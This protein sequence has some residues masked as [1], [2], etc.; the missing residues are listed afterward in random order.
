[1]IVYFADRSMNIIGHA[2]D[3]IGNS[4]KIANDSSVQEIENGVETLSFDI[5]F[6]PATRAE[7]EKIAEVGNYILKYTGNKDQHKLY[8]IIDSELNVNDR[9]INIF[10]ED[11][12]L[13]LL[14]ETAG[15]FTPTKEMTATEYIEK[16]L[17][18]TG[19][20]IG[21]NESETTK[22]AIVF[23]QDETVTKRILQIASEFSLE[24]DYSVTIK[25]LSVTGK[26][27]N[28]YKRIGSDKAIEL[29][30][31][32][33]IDNIIVKKSIANLCTGIYPMGSSPDGSVG[34]ISGKTDTEKTKYT[35]VRF[36][37][38]MNGADGF[39][40][41]PSRHNFIGIAEDKT[42][43][44]E[45]ENYK[46]YKWYRL[47]YERVI[48]VVPSQNGLLYKKKE[49]SDNN[50]YMWIRFSENED[51]SNMTVNP[52]AQT[53]YIG[54]AE[55][56][57]SSTPSS[58]TTDYNWDTYSGSDTKN[59]YLTNSS[60]RLGDGR[61]CLVRFADDKTGTNMSSSAAGKAYVGFSCDFEDSYSASAIDYIWTAFDVDSDDPSRGANPLVNGGY[62]EFDW[63]MCGLMEYSGSTPKNTYTWVRFAEDE[64]GYGINGDGSN[65]KYIGFKYGQT[66]NIP[67]N[68]A[69]VYSWHPV[70]GDADTITLVGYSYDKDD[71]YVENGVVY[72][73][74]ATQKWSRY[75][76]PFETN[77]QGKDKG[78]IVRRISYNFG[79]PDVLLY[80]AIADLKKYGDPEV[81]YDVSVK[82]LP[83]NVYIGDRI[84]IVDD[85]GLL[86]V[87]ARILQIDRSECND[88]T[89]ITLGEFLIK[90]S[91]ISN[92]VQKL[93]NEFA[94]YAAKTPQKGENAITIKMTSSNGTSFKNTDISTTLIAHVY[95]GSKE[96]SKAEVAAL[97]V[98]KW[99]RDGVYFPNDGALSLVVTGFIAQTSEGDIVLPSTTEGTNAVTQDVNGYI[100]IPATGSLVGNSKNVYTVQLETAGV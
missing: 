95:S 3:A 37:D 53:R 85:A 69:S 70:A 68:S 46:D 6:T 78:A 60:Y 42:E 97:G 56:M 35:W 11:G 22:K 65:A 77:R 30:T 47:N 1:M 61:Y 20:K 76:A 43:F 15:P 66:T 89:K 18:D 100:V 59:L 52:N 16:Y 2:S 33:E 92:E 28:I 96:L 21:K 41:S 91:G 83:E 93:A 4:Y 87:S 25:G 26:F 90:D 14:N 81:N 13:D 64:T 39:E 75:Q 40:D 73:R 9:T 29:R 34:Y 17:Y 72:S 79:D 8:T 98:L 86:Y 23:D 5:Y 82:Y 58:N 99:Y 27:I 74:A 10:S 24:I 45:S 54:I 49:S 51:G 57:D 62:V 84:N 19:F 31:D 80:M 50:K 67:S 63:S 88:T 71:I 94:V 32:R 48:R 36:S 12:G 44:L 55:N 7:V 38:S